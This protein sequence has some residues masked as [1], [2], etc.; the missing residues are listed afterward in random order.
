MEMG[1]VDIVT[2]KEKLQEL[3]EN[4]DPN[5]KFME[6]SKGRNKGK[7]STKEIK[8]KNVFQSQFLIDSLKIES[9]ANTAKY[10]MK[11]MTKNINTD[12]NQQ[13]IK[14]KES[15][16]FNDER[17]NNNEYWFGY[18]LKDLDNHFKIKF[19]KRGVNLMRKSRFFLSK[20]VNRLF[21]KLFF[22]DKKEKMRTRFIEDENGKKIE[23]NPRYNNYYEFLKFALD[24]K[25]VEYGRKKTIRKSKKIITGEAKGIIYEPKL[26]TLHIH[27][28]DKYKIYKRENYD[29]NEIQKRVEVHFRISNKNIFIQDSI[30]KIITF[31]NVKNEN[32]EHFT[33]NILVNGSDVSNTNK[34]PF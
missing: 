11:Y 4:K 13:I 10:V 30:N 25:I 8:N 26:N 18:L 23:M 22:I 31:S 28:R 5:F 6:L 7:L 29:L 21:N 16:K 17:K 34:I 32:I 19:R 2:S 33:K 9:K 24:K 12:I 27:Y 3:K 14:E 1:R 15:K 20:Q